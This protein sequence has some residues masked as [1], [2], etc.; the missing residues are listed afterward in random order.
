MKNIFTF[1]LCAALGGCTATKPDGRASATATD[2]PADTAKKFYWQL[3][4]P[5]TAADETP[6]YRRLTV[7]IPAHTEG[8]V[9]YEEQTRTILIAE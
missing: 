4:Q 5:P 9:S 7:T 3:Q 6:H 8:G 2:G 1:I